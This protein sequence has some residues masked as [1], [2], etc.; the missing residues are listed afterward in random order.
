MAI[1]VIQQT[2]FITTG[3][4]LG[5]PSVAYNSALAGGNFLL[6]FCSYRSNSWGSPA[7]G[8]LIVRPFLDTQSNSWSYITLPNNYQ[9]QYSYGIGHSASSS[10]GSDT[11]T[12]DFSN[13]DGFI[14][15]TR[16]ELFEIS[17]VSTFNL[18]TFN[19]AASVATGSIS[20][21]TGTVNFSTTT[22]IS[23]YWACDMVCVADIHG[24]NIV[25]AHPYNGSS[26]NIHDTISGWTSIF[27][28][29]NDNLYVQSNNVPPPAPVRLFINAGATRPLSSFQE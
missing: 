24:N 8:G 5:I 28:G 4:Q 3:A 23:P 18:S 17:G 1:S 2:N 14:Y 26:L 15:D 9:G 19:G 13:N 11:V 6:G 27:A 21:P 7:S 10:A 16:I 20:T 22:S 12:I 25:Y 29:P